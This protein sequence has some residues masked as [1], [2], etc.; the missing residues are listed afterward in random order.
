MNCFKVFILKWDLK[1]GFIED[2]IDGLI[3]VLVVD[4]SYRRRC[5]QFMI[6]ISEIKS[7]ALEL[8]KLIFTL[9]FCLFKI[10]FRGNSW[11]KYRLIKL[12]L[13]VGPCL[14]DLLLHVLHYQFDLFGLIKIVDQFGEVIYVIFIVHFCELFKDYKLINTCMNL[15]TSGFFESS[16]LLLIFLHAFH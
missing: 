4:Y 8:S 6:Q 1:E 15:L 2:I 12:K 13:R 10:F 3:F 5:K 7:F 11:V 14:L 9:V 16:N